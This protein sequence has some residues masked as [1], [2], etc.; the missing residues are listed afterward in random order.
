MGAGVGVTPTLTENDLTVRVKANNFIE[1]VGAGVGVYSTLTEN[2]LT[3]RVKAN[4][5]DDEVG[6]G[7]MGLLFL[8]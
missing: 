2:E 5:F 3:V 8:S 1:E 6:A 7:S 4:I